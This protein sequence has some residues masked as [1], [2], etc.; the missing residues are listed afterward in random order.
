MD[1]KEFE[2]S[3]NEILLQEYELGN[4]FDVVNIPT[5]KIKNNKNIFKLLRNKL[6]GYVSNIKILNVVENDSTYA[7]MCYYYKKEDSDDYDQCEI[8]VANPKRFTR[9]EYFL[10]TLLHEIIHAVDGRRSFERDSIFSECVAEIGSWLCF[11]NR[12][13]IMI[14]GCSLLSQVTSFCKDDPT[15]IK[16]KLLECY[17]EATKLS[18]I[19]KKNYIWDVLPKEGEVL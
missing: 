10:K 1:I 5:E 2:K 9:Y 15:M 11:P 7:G 17:V 6:Y 18:N 19:L 13:N 12:K 8:I 14:M 16:S 3:I 4:Y